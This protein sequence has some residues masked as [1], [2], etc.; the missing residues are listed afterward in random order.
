MFVE[1]RDKEMAMSRNAMTSGL[2]ASVTLVLGFMGGVTFGQSSPP[3]ETKGQTVVLLQSINL[4]EEID[5]VVGRP[6][7]LRRI[8]L[9]PGGIIS[10][11]SH[12]DRPTVSLF[13]QGEAIFHQTD[14]PDLIVRAGEGFAEGKA[15]THWVENRGSVS[16]VWIAAD[17]PRTP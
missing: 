14:K 4:T 13:L 11:H 3:S 7:R 6:L 2:F 16:A 12:K 9:E 10:L 5:S 8:T 15:T 17:V 1:Q